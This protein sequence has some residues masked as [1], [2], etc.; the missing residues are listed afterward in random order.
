MSEANAATPAGQEGTTPP[1]VPAATPANNAGQGETVT[2]S[3]EEAEQLRRDAARA[4][5][6]QS[7]ADRYDRMTR[8][9]GGHFKPQA[10]A[11]PPSEDEQKA[12]AEAEDRKAEKGLLGLAADPAYREAL[13]ADPTLRTLLTTNPLAI[14]PAYAPDALDAEDAIALVKEKL[15]TRVEEIKK[16]KT[17]PPAG[18]PEQ[19]PATPPAPPAGGVNPPAGTTPDADYEAAKKQPNTERALA[20]MIKVGLNKMGGK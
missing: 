4:S 6:N 1:A 13:D 17:P 18:A 16:S 7:K 14:L 9:G 15:A 10:P 20:G 8:N 11:T 3:K 5:A 2:L 19:K 12:A